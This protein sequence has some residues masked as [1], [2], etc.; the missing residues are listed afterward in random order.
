[1]FRWSL[2]YFL[3]VNQLH[4]ARIPRTKTELKPLELA[5]DKDNY[6][7][8]V[9]PVSLPD[10]SALARETDRFLASHKIG[11]PV[12]VRCICVSVTI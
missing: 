3:S 9:S 6:G 1:M 2:L 4:S 10:S 8:D 12:Q 11:P 7:E 5:R